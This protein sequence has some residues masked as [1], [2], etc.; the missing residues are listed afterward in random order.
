M[1][2]RDQ[3]HDAFVEA[4][5]LLV[6]AGVCRI[7]IVRPYHDPTI[8]LPADLYDAVVDR[9]LANNEGPR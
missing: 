2:A 4:V 6:R 1:Q 8:R 3:K 9:I 7:E 5:A